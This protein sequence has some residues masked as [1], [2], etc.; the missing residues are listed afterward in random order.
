MRRICVEDCGSSSLE[1][2]ASTMEGWPGESPSKRHSEGWASL[3]VELLTHKTNVYRLILLV[4]GCCQFSDNVIVLQP[5]LS[6]SCF[7]FFFVLLLK[8]QFLM[9]GKHLL[10]LYI[11]NE[12]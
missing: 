6:D 11:F 1:K 3:T 9:G 4:K 2:K 12:S 8:K 5:A 10:Y 7:C